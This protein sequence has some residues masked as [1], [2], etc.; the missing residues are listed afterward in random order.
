MAKYGLFEME[1]SLLYMPM[2]CADFAARAKA[3]ALADHCRQ[4]QRG[5][6]PHPGQL[7]KAL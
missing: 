5:D 3:S 2:L 1:V 4:I 7:L 6:V